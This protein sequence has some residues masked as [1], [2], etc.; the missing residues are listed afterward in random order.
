VKNGGGNAT[1]NGAI[2]AA[3][4]Y[5]GNPGAS[6]PGAYPAYPT[7]IALG[8]NNPPGKP[9]FGWNGGGNATFQYDSCW[10]QAI[11]Q[12]YPYHIVAQRELSY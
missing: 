12:A 3:N 9:F 11:N 6:G 8:A 2:F 7:R 1:L 5:T 10:I 4:L